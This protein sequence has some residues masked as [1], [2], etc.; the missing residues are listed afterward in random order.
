MTMDVMEWKVLAVDDDTSNIDDLERVLLTRMGGNKFT[1]T[2]VSSFDKGIA[3]IDDH[4]FDF[5]FL[6][7]HE[8]I[9]DPKPSEQPGIE[10]Q[11]G[12]ELLHILQSK[13]SLPVIFYTGY[14]D[15]VRH[16]ESM[17]VGIVDK[18]TT[19]DDIRKAVQK[20]METRLP[21]LLRYI[22]EQSRSYI[23]DSLNEVLNKHR[24]EI[25]PPDVSLLLAR[26][27]ANILSQSVVKDLLEMDSSKIN[28]LEMYQYPPSELSC[29]P[30]DIYRKNCDGSLWM[31][32]TPACDF[33]QDNADNILL[34]KITPLQDLPVYAEWKEKALTYDLIQDKAPEKKAAKTARNNAGGKV[35]SLIKDGA[36]KR[37]KFLPGTFFLPDCIVDFQE[38]TNCPKEH[39]N[40]YEV[41]CSMDSPYRE[42]MLNSF[43]KYY[44]RIGTPD[45]DK[46]LLIND[47]ESRLCEA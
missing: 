2:K 26:R 3:L 41:I 30:A 46:N 4:R 47:I 35:K 6:D 10:D 43:S 45:Y 18:G 20:I 14:P 15:K 17:F 21:H 7:V 34:A 19:T 31:I 16:L 5:V 1:F 42:E 23:W 12:E 39:A 24:D 11:R 22:E 40:G 33:A 28:P 27:L 13:R 38:L 32:F 29:S 44:G 37:Y 8:E 25:K 36:G 9:R